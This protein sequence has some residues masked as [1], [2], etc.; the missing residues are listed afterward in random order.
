MAELL[1]K[2]QEKVTASGLAPNLCSLNSAML[3]QSNNLSKLIPKSHLTCMCLRN[4]TALGLLR[5][6]IPILYPTDNMSDPRERLFFSGITYPS[7]MS[8]VVRL[9]D[10]WVAH[11]HVIAATKEFPCAGASQQVGRIHYWALFNTLTFSLEPRNC[12]GV[13]I[14]SPCSLS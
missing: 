12:D 6:T 1:Q 10:N 7:S 2:I 11:G 4:P 5:K 13:D 14:D 9:L 3:A 8:C